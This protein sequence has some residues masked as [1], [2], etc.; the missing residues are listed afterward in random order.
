[1]EYYR[2]FGFS[3]AHIIARDPVLGGIVTDAALQKTWDAFR[4]LPKP[5]L[6]HCSAGRD[7]TGK[8]VEYLLKELEQ[9]QG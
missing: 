1:M 3:V 4:K 9:G 7:R 2:Q 6:V 5:M 8:A